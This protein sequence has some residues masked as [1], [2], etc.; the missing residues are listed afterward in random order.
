[1][2]LAT[3]GSVPEAAVKELRA[4]KGVLEVHAISLA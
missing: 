3:Y 1:M 2:V 4:T